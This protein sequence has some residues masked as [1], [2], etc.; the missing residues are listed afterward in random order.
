MLYLLVETSLLLLAAAVAFFLLGAYYQRH[1]A[2]KGVDSDESTAAWDVARK[3]DEEKEWLRRRLAEL[4]GK[5]AALATSAANRDDRAASAPATGAAPTADTAASLV[6]A[7]RAMEARLEGIVSRRFEAIE[8]RLA[9]IAATPPAA[10]ARPTG[11]DVA[12]LNAIAAAERRLTQAMAEQFAKLDHADDVAGDPPTFVPLSGAPAAGDDPITA[13]T[14]RFRQELS[15][16][17]ERLTHRINATVGPGAANGEQRSMVE[18]LQRIEA[19]ISTIT[20]TDAQ[21][22]AEQLVWLTAAVARIEQQLAHGVVVSTATPPPAQAGEAGAEGPTLWSTPETAASQSPELRQIADA[23]QRMERHVASI[24]TSSSDRGS[25]APDGTA[26]VQQLLRSLTESVKR[27]ERQ[28]DAMRITPPTWDYSADIRSLASAFARLERHLVEMPNHSV[29][30]SIDVDTLHQRFDRIEQQI[31]H[32]VTTPSAPD[33]SPMYGMLQQLHQRFDA[34]EFRSALSAAGNAPGIGNG[35]PGQGPTL[36][37]TPKSQEPTSE[38][39]N[40]VAELLAETRKELERL[41]SAV[42]AVENGTH[43][44]F[45]GI[46]RQILAATKPSGATKAA[47]EDRLERIERRLEEMSVRSEQAA[48]SLSQIASAEAMDRLGDELRD[49]T[50]TLERR[51]IALEVELARQRE[52]LKRLAEQSSV[53]HPIDPAADPAVQALESAK[54]ELSGRMEAIRASLEQQLAGAHSAALDSGLEEK[55]DRLEERL[56]AHV[57]QAATQSKSDVS[58]MVEALRMDLAG[59]RVA[60]LQSVSATRPPT[61]ELHGIR[62]EIE[63][64]RGAIQELGKETAES[65]RESDLLQRIH[66]LERAAL[67]REK[68]F[69][70]RERRLDDEYQERVS[71]LER[72]LEKLEAKTERDD[73]EDARSAEFEALAARLEEKER[74]LE[75][76]EAELAERVAVLERDVAE[77]HREHPESEALRA[78]LREAEAALAKVAEERRAEEARRDLERRMDERLAEVQ[79]DSRELREELR[80]IST[81]LREAPEPPPAPS[82]PPLAKELLAR[83]EKLEDLFWENA[84]EMKQLV[85]SRASMSEASL[86]A[87]AERLERASAATM[88]TTLDTIRTAISGLETRWS[89]KDTSLR[90]ELERR[91]GELRELVASELTRRDVG[92]NDIWNRTRDSLA[93]RLEQLRAQL[94]MQLERQTS[95]WKE[96]ERALAER[97]ELKLERSMDGVAEALRRELLP[98]FDHLQLALRMSASPSTTPTAAPTES[99]SRAIA[100]VEDRLRDIERAL[101][102]TP[103]GAGD[104]AARALLERELRELSEKV[105]EA[106]RC[107]RDTI[108]RLEQELD[109]ARAD[110]RASKE[111]DGLREDQM[112]RGRYGM[113]GGFMDPTRI[114]EELDERVSEAEEH[115]EKLSKEIASVSTLEARLRAEREAREELEDRIRE[116]EHRERDRQSLLDNALERTRSEQSRASLELRSELRREIDDRVRDAEDRLGRRV[117]AMMP[118]H[119]MMGFGM[120]G[121]A[122]SATALVDIERRVRDALEMLRSREADLEKTM[123][124]LRERSHGDVEAKIREAVREAVDDLERRVKAMQEDAQLSEP[125]TAALRAYR[126]RLEALEQ[127]VETLGARAAN[128]MLEGVEDRIRE[129]EA[130]GRDQTTALYADIDD[131]RRSLA[132]ERRALE[133]KVEGR[134]AELLAKSASGADGEDTEKLRKELEETNDRFQKQMLAMRDYMVKLDKAMKPLEERLGNFESQLAARGDDRSVPAEAVAALNE[135]L[136]QLESVNPASAEKLESLANELN[137][138]VSRVRGIVDSALSRL[139]AVESRVDGAMTQLERA[140]AEWK[141][142]SEER[143]EDLV[144]HIDHLQ[145]EMREE[146][147]ERENQLAGGIEPT[148]LRRIEEED[149]RRFRQLQEKFESLERTF[150]QKVEDLK[151]DLEENLHHSEERVHDEAV[152]LASRTDERLQK[153]VVGLEKLVAEKERI[154][155]ELSER[156]KAL[157]EQVHQNPDD[158]TDIAGIGPKLKKKLKEE[159]GITTFKALATISAADLERL[160]GMLLFPDR[161]FRED[162]IGQARE[163]H[164][165]KYNE[166]LP[167]NDAEGEMRMRLAS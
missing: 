81:I 32:A 75:E 53:P 55:L 78:R 83:I 161:I 54:Q 48:K 3:K 82:E 139:E 44:R 130:R 47:D 96:A 76:R 87:L 10:P 56:V 108:R 67:E 90:D 51:T 24:T 98:K 129:L 7:I 148:E 150:G 133:E 118:S 73:R 157:T 102:A 37:S 141:A 31:A 1:F 110:R 104:E 36:C 94:A 97:F 165:R 60:I 122:M 21:F 106:E 58:P 69:E 116:L 143:I 68:E 101:Y 50:A 120:G 79:R 41:A 124:E 107:S 109:A 28:V 4:E 5:L 42:E 88:A 146:A 140:V 166:L 163:L 131:L 152:T 16:L 22:P 70:L 134:L 18:A 8:A 52:Q 127:R 123:S 125:V 113:G 167:P 162:W 147:L 2:A 126:E 85:A 105:R 39:A 115:F 121:D 151:H 14:Q 153:M 66:E 135:R 40:P 119:P 49:S 27:L 19:K 138:A 34:L 114:L 80:D 38:P 15:S 100:R 132:A 156:V 46:E 160:A 86:A 74:R 77:T 159:F 9:D 89:E 164:L 142:Q 62:T 11:P 30:A 63:R 111:T 91:L 23:F 137:S 45:D 43:A 20:A 17:E 59:L 6:P 95:D 33:L 35:Y 144:A 72:E 71:T 112:P 136:T 25:S 117:M 154:I 99:D 61:A 92:V 155:E 93:E 64:L 158:L 12:T 103:V 149:L 13:L 26:E 84:A 145:E 128:A 29:R 65:H 57:N